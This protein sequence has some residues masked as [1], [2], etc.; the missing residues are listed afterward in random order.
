M[1]FETELRAAMAELVAGTNASPDLIIGVRRLHRR[2]TVRQ[3][4]LA[5]SAVAVAA[6]AAIPL[7]SSYGSDSGGQGTGRGVLTPPTGG[8]TERR[9]GP[10]PDG[11]VEGPAS[12]DRRSLCAV[13][14]RQDL[15]GDQG[16]GGRPEATP[17]GPQMIGID[18]VEVRYLPKKVANLPAGELAQAPERESWG[19]GIT[20][21]DAQGGGGSGR[22]RVTV[23][24]VCGPASLDAGLLNGLKGLISWSSPGNG[25]LVKGRPGRQEPGHAAWIVRPGVGID[26]Q[27][28]KDVDLGKVLN[29]IKVTG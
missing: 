23:T 1:N 24:V 13:E 26:V 5:A 8:L 21:S 17:I 14:L 27:V 15:R 9:G 18:G 2:R 22:T 4:T 16:T 11:A 25:A 10:Q 29:G 19:Y 6:V 12:Q 3:R 20:W 7:M 28:S